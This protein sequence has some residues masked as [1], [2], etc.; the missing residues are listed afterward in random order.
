MRAGKLLLTAGFLFGLTVAANG[1]VQ[2]PVSE[3]ANI[4]LEVVQPLSINVTQHV[5]FTTL[6]LNS[7]TGSESAEGK[8][9][10][11]GAQGHLVD[12]N[13][14]PSSGSVL[15]NSD[16]VGG[17]T[18]TIAYT[19][20]LN[21]DQVTLGADGTADEGDYLSTLTVTLTETPSA[22]GS[23]TGDILIT[24]TYN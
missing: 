10:V 9:T 15:T 3:T 14:T 2:G 11:S 4:T 5:D 18:A 8:F 7:M 20:S 19:A 23:Y 1:A 21:S 12:L 24:A 17:S 22:I 16:T 13:L 6:N